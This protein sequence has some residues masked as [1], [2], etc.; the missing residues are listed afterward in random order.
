M[1]ISKKKKDNVLNFS[2]LLVKYSKDHRNN[3]AIK[4]KR[5]TFGIY[6]S[7]KKKNYDSITLTISPML[8]QREDSRDDQK[9]LETTYVNKLAR[10]QVPQSQPDGP[11]SIKSR[12][13][14]PF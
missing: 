12:L 14:P 7:K 6:L 4:H 13:P 10:W 1:V 3:C 2:V 11:S 5:N 8:T 9:L